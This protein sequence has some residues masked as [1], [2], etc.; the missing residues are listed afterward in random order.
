MA[1]YELG[2]NIDLHEVA[3]NPEYAKQKHIKVKQQNELTI[4]RYDKQFLRLDNINTLGL[5]RSVIMDG[6]EVICF[7]PPKSLNCNE[8]MENFS[9]T[10]CSQEYFIEGTMV[11]CFYHKNNWRI[12][13][14][15]DIDANGHFYS[16]GNKSFNEMFHESLKAIN[17]QLSD[18]N[19][20]YCYSFV[21]QHPEN[22]IVVPFISPC[23]ILVAIYKC[24]GNCVYDKTSKVEEEVLSLDIP[25]PKKFNYT[26]WKTIQDVFASQSTDYKVLGLIFKHNKTCVR[27]KIRNP[28]YEKVRKLKGNQSKIQYQY[29]YLYQNDKVQEF[30]KYYPEYKNMFWEFRNELVRWTTRLFELYRDYHVHKVIVLDDIP[31][32]F[33]THIWELHQIYLTRLKNQGFSITKKDVIHYIYNLETARLMYAINYPMRV[34]SMDSKIGINCAKTAEL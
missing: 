7:S 6:D 32:Q 22:R 14:R 4:L 27:S 2:K 13:T 18:L 26:D 17:L 24:D 30:L 21:L 10:E 9:P 12:A 16:D 20:D 3:N 23:V 29:Y 19:T 5:F 28:I 15:W 34:A 11:N 31:S 33:R 25:T 8:F 1:T